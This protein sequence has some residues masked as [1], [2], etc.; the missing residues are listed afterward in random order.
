MSMDGGSVHGE[1]SS[2]ESIDGCAAPQ[3]L[4]GAVAGLTAET[5][6]SRSSGPTTVR[7]YKEAAPNKTT[8][9][10]P[11][12]RS[13]TIHAVDLPCEPFHDSFGVGHLRTHDELPSRCVDDSFWV[14]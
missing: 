1:L 13:V 9:L 5:P 11:G 4:A 8:H 10:D 12:R 2:G 3:G 14:V 6:S 7:L